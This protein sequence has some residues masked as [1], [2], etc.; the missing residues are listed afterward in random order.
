[1]SNQPRYFISQYLDQLY[2]HGGI[3]YVDAERVL[4]EQGYTPLTLS[5]T[6]SGQPGKFPGMAGYLRRLRTVRTIAR[7][8]EPAS[9]V[10]FVFPVFARMTRLL[11]RMLKRRGVRIICLVYDLD[12]FRDGKPR[13]LRKELNK[14]NGYDALVVHNDTMKQWM[15]AHG[16]SVPMASLG[17][18][19]FLVNT[20]A[21]D[22]IKRNRVVFASELRNKGFLRDRSAL[23]SALADVSLD[24]YGPNFPRELQGTPGVVD[25]GVLPATELPGRMDGSFGLIWDG[26][27]LG[28]PS[29]DLGAYMKVI[30]QHKLSLYIVSG[31]PVIIHEQAASAKLVLKYNIGFTLSQLS[32]ISEKI[33]ALPEESYELMRRNM[34]PLADEIRRG[35]RLMQC[36]EELN[37]R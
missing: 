29:G 22:R 33:K 16:I 27:S 14:L 1:M 13:L 21:P 8:V 32:E 31:L 2:P 35:K 28:E 23:I 18:F 17:F 5:G 30:S 10:V 11:V 37:E 12:G 24:C 20:Q 15:A 6:G 19:D 26:D 3:G 4:Q 36:L 9:I 25:H 34:I 7:S